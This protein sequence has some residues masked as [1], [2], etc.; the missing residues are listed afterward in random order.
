[1]HVAILSWSVCTLCLHFLRTRVLP[2]VNGAYRCSSQD[3]Y[4]RSIFGFQQGC[5]IGYNSTAMPPPATTCT[6]ANNTC[7]FVEG[8]PTCVSWL[9]DCNIEYSCTTEADFSAATENDETACSFPASPPP[10]PNAICIPVNDTCEWHNPCR[11]WQNWCGG[12]YRCGSEAQYAAF[13]NGPQPIC[14]FPPFNAT[15][16]VPA[17]ECVYQDGQCVWSGKTNT[18]KHCG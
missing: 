4:Y 2:C 8:A 7:A 18:T 10:T 1:M 9:R 14:A 12:E 13:I 5:P 17:G 16:R 3:E 15:S 6:L 11:T